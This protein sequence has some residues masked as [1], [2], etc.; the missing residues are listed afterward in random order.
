[1]GKNKEESIISPGTFS[2]RL[3]KEQHANTNF[4]PSLPL[5]PLPPSLPYLQ[6]RPPQLVG[7]GKKFEGALIEQIALDGLGLGLGV[8]VP[9]PGLEGV[10]VAGDFLKRRREGGVSGMSCGQPEPCIEEGVRVRSMLGSGQPFILL[11]GWCCLLLL[12]LLIFLRTIITIITITY[13]LHVRPSLL[14]SSLV[15]PTQNV[16]PQTPRL[17]RPPA[18]PGSRR[19]CRRRPPCCL[20][21]CVASRGSKGEICVVI[22]PGVEA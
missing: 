2:G 11:E 21:G 3:K 9:E 15:H 1:M 17:V 12:D 8:Q 18:V 19:S 10:G 22:L 16:P 5:S 7:A 20:C 14:A 4:F 6:V 13:L